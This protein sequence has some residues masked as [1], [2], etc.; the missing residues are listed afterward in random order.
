[1]DEETNHTTVMKEWSSVN[2]SILA[3]ILS[4]DTQLRLGYILISE[5]DSRKVTPKI[6]DVRL[7]AENKK[8]L[9]I[10][11]RRGIVH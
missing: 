6:A 5:I 11:S 3:T 4:S 8:D 10:A 1:M 7:D 2:H 9:R